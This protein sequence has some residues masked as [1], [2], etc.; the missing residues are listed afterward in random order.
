M[1]GWLHPLI[2]WLNKQRR[3]EEK[4]AFSQVGWCMEGNSLVIPTSVV[5]KFGLGGLAEYVAD[6]HQTPDAPPL[7]KNLLNN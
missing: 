6:L 4:L 1:F 2:T 7:K 3:K 5:T